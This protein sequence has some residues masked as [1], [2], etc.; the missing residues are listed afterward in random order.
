VTQEVI[1]EYRDEPITE[2][3]SESLPEPQPIE[4]S[5]TEKIVENHTETIE[6]IE[7]SDVS[8]PEMNRSFLEEDYSMPRAFESTRSFTKVEP[9]KSE[10]VKLS[11]QVQE[12]IYQLL[13]SIKTLMARGQTL[14]AR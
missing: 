12:K 8:T 1:S 7:S 3:V 4:E 13:G 14:E 9:K 2:I 10:S 5:I 6:P 11:P